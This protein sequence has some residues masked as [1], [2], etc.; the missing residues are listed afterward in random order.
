RHTAIG[1]ARPATTA[2]HFARESG[3]FSGPCDKLLSA[4]CGRLRRTADVGA[5]PMCLCARRG[6]L[7]WRGQL[8]VSGFLILWV[9][10]FGFGF[11]FCFGCLVFA[12]GFGF[13]FGCLVFAP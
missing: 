5:G 11:G 3:K 2:R 6:R 13:C 9:S 12:L 7:E 4:C 10:G 1:L 8:W